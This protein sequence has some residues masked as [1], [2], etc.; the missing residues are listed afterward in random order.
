MKLK[1]ILSAALLL[2]FSAAMANNDTETQPTG[3]PPESNIDIQLLN[4][5]VLD[6]DSRKPLKDVNVTAIYQSKKEK[7]VST[8]INGGFSFVMLKPG[9]YRL[10]FEKEGYKKVIKE[11]VEIKEKEPVQMNIEMPQFIPVSERGPSAWHF[12]ES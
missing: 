1:Y 9:T 12:F 11:K 8:D 7:V 5:V 2:F 10:V 3:T 6:M 4:G